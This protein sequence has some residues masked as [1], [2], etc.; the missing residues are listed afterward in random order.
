MTLSRLSG[1]VNASVVVL[2]TYDSHN[3]VFHPVLQVMKLYSTSG[4]FWCHLLLPYPS[5]FKVLLENSWKQGLFVTN[6]FSNSEVFFEPKNL[7]FN[8]INVSIINPYQFLSKKKILLTLRKYI[9]VAVWKNIIRTPF[10]QVPLFFL[11]AANCNI[12]AK[13][14][15]VTSLVRVIPLCGQKKAQLMK[16]VLYFFV[17]F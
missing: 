14:S 5:A 15:V 9:F 10:C 7:H 6:N 4:M 16:Y 11:L 17:K 3:K 8:C 13:G 2:K 12:L 1:A